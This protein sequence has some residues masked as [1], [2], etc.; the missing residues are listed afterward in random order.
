MTDVGLARHL[1]SAHRHTIALTEEIARLRDGLAEA[2]RTIADL[3]RMYESARRASITDPLTGRLNRAG[4]LD[5]W[6]D[7]TAWCQHRRSPT[8]LILL[9]LDGFKAINDTYGHAAGD[10]VLQHVGDLIHG[11]VGD[12]AARLGGDEFGVLTRCGEATRDLADLISEMIETSMVQG[13]V[14]RLDDEVSSAELQICSIRVRASIGWV[15]IHPSDRI[16]DVFLH[17]DIALYHAKA[18]SRS[19]SWWRSS[20]SQTVEWEQGMAMPQAPEPIRR[21]IRGMI[22]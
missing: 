18:T 19:R 2:E 6:E 13:L 12:R 21:K 8:G 22:K 16:R 14:S 1:A 7:H 10:M 3:E 5:L 4:L 11:L 15:R 9:D 17:A 20:S